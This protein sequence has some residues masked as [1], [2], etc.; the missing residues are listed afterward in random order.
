[1]VMEKIMLKKLLEDCL[2]HL[3]NPTPDRI[4]WVKSGL[5][6]AIAFVEEEGVHIKMDRKECPAQQSIIEE[7]AILPREGDTVRM[8]TKDLLKEFGW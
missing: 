2:R 7:L 3:D 6:T 1:M 8:S 5:R 4:E